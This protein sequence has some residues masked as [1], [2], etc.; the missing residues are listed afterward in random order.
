MGARS[1]SNNSF[2]C[3]DPGAV[4]IYSNGAAVL[5]DANHWSQQPAGLTVDYGGSGITGASRRLHPGDALLPVTHRFIDR[6]S[7]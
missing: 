5:I 2:G 3:Y 1:P 4:G 6:Y 7:L